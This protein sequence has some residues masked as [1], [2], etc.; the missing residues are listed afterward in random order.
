M[1]ASIRILDAQGRPIRKLLNRQ[2]IAQGAFINWDGLGDNGE[3]ARVGY[4]L[5]STEVFDL[6]GQVQ[7]LQMK[8]VVGAK[9]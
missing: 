4:Y 2:T 9:F 1:V 3:K 7:R 6:N 8:A 5:L